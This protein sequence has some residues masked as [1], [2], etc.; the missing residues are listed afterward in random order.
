MNPRVTRVA[1]FAAS[2]WMLYLS[3]TAD[4]PGDGRALLFGAAGGFLM[5]TAVRPRSSS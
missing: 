5:Y 1:C 4:N 3:W 2:L